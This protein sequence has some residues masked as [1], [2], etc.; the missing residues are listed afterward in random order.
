L[1]RILQNYE[2]DKISISGNV[3]EFG[4]S[5]LS[6]NN[7]SDIAK[8]KNIK[9]IHFSDKNIIHKDVINV[10]LNKKINLKK[11]YYN[12]VIYFN[13]ME[14]LTNPDNANKEIYKIMKK[15]GILIGSA[16]FLYRFH[17][18]PSDYL[19]FTKP[20]LNLFFR[21]KFRIVHVKN[22]GFGP[23]CLSYSFLS[24][25]TKKIPFLN[26]ILF[27]LTYFLDFILSML[28][29]YDLKDIYPIATFFR[30]KK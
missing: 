23:F 14:H 15:N 21:K 22:L 6:K 27:S 28:V 29:K 12:T 24:D 2:T 16:P 8:K 17:A 25:F 10:D 7:F 1:C 11:D 30:I 5:P 9:L 13:V 4:A 19:R 18:A 3:I 20:Y 26:L